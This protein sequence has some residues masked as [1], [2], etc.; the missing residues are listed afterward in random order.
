MKEYLATLVTTAITP[1]QGRNLTREYL[2]ARILRV[3]QH[4]GAFIPLAFHGGTALR[5]LYATPRYSEDLDFA[6]EHARE[7]YDFRTY[8]KAIQHAMSVEGYKVTVKVNDRKT[9][10]SAFVRFPG[11]LYELQLS[12]HQDENLSVKLEVDTAPPEGAGLATTVVRRHV[13]LH[14]QHHDRASL[15]AGKL[16]AILQR[17]YSKGR[18]LYDLLWYLS[19]PGWPAPNMNMLNNALAQSGW[20]GE[21]MTLQNWRGVIGVR[22]RELDWVRTVADVRP[23]LESGTD[24]DLLTPDI[25]LGLLTRDT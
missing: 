12:P 19:D 4:V 14:L 6:L 21:V 16:H 22:L 15:L 11:L 7:K 3:L 8:L 25:L 10:H 20:G 9:V 13:I 17:P 5:F 1:I 18:D 2:Q 23:F 24:I